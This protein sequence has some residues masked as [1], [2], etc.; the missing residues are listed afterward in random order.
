MVNM[1]NIDGSWQSI[2]GWLDQNASSK[3]TEYIVGKLVIAASTYFVWQERNNR[4]FSNTKAN[5]EVVSEKIKGT[6]RLRL[7]GFKFKSGASNQRLLK[8]WNIV[9]SESEIDPG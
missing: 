4:L 2:L 7:M 9:P 5:V 6:I 1:E 8:K 3:K